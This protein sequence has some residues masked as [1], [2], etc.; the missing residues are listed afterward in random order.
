MSRPLDRPLDRAEAFFWFL[1]RC[2]SMNFA[3]LAEGSGPLEADR[4]EAALARAQE[5]HP[6]LAVAIDTDAAGRLAFVPRPGAA[7]AFTRE[8]AGED[9]HAA[10]AARLAVPFGLGEAPLVRAHWFGLPAGRWAF[11]VVF[12]HA[13]G[14]GRSGFRL[15]AELIDDARGAGG[16][17]DPV[18]PRPSLMALFPEALAGDAGLARAQ[19]WK[20]E[21]KA[22][23]LRAD[24]VPGFRREEG[25]EVR[26]A[27]HALRFDER[28]VEGLAARARLEGA[29]VHGLIGAAELLA[30]RSLFEGEASP[31]L[32]L[33]SPVDLRGSLAAPVDDATPGF[34]VTLLSSLARV[35]GPESLGALAGHLTRDLRRQIGQGCGHL[36]YHLAAPAETIPPT[37]EGVAG[38]RAWMR[39]MPPAFLLSNVGRAG[40]MPEAGG[41]SV[42][43]ISFALC[44]MAHQPLFVA[45]STWGG[46]LALNVVHDAAR[47]PGAPAGALASRMRELLLAAAG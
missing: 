23:P 42:R 17:R 11:A 9:W 14:D 35:G 30:A 37:A 25:G 39:R 2:S 18:A 47:L 34:Y 36:F 7:A 6:A 13:I 38:F 31:T 29:S 12:H 22:E 1:D 41:V 33:T 5:R 40:S 19:A 10:L 44:P 16:A 45:A 3:I 27:I 28:V 8:A 20:A 26:P 24:A 21:L 15:A 4:L 46:R 43:E 32:M